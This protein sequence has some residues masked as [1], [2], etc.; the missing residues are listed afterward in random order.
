MTSAAKSIPRPAAP[1]VPEPFDNASPGDCILQ[2]SDGLKYK[3]FR[4]ILSLASPVFRSMFELPQP[5]IPADVMAAQDSPKLSDSPDLQVIPVSETS[6]T[7]YT[8]LLLLYPAT[9][10]QIS[11]Y[12]LVVEVI[13][14][15]DKYDINI[16][17]LHPFLHDTLLSEDGLASN[18]LGV[19]AV[20]WRLGMREE[21]QKASRYLHS[22]NLNDTTVKDDLLSRSG[23]L[24]ALLEL[25]DLRVR[26][27]RALDEIV[28]AAPL[29]LVIC[30]GH[31]HFQH[32]YDQNE[33][34]YLALLRTKARDSL[35][36]P[37]PAWSNVHRF[38]GISE[39]PWGNCGSC[40]SQHRNLDDR[41]LVK[42]KG[43]V[44]AFPQAVIW[45]EAI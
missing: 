27:E 23:D 25:W 36:E 15:Y 31:Q 35:A 11:S 20:A 22:V 9:V 19:Y 12:D 8:L 38:F 28:G 26:R 43:L 32:W 6:T 44:A 42:L 34:K 5:S 30:G 40:M 16:K 39:M 2:S 37:Y 29:R 14:A 18:P 41:E 33:P 4:I 21:A 45:Y 13:E 3:V 24:E 1:I 17:S 10:V 7:L